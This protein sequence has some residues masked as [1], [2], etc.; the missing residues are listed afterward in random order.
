MNRRDEDDL[1]DEQGAD[2]YED[3]LEDESENELEDEAEFEETESETDD[4]EEE[5]IEDEEQQEEEAE[6]QREN[7]SRPKKRKEFALNGLEITRLLRVKKTQIEMLEDR[8]YI[9]PE[10]QLQFKTITFE[11]FNTRFKNEN[12]ENLFVNILSGEY[13]HSIDRS[14]LYVFYPIPTPKQLSS[15]NIQSVLNLITTR[16]DIRRIIIITIRKPSS[17]LKKQI[18]N[19]ESKRLHA[20]VKNSIR[21]QIFLQNE[22]IYNPSKHFLV[23]KHII[24]DEEE[25]NNLS[26]MINLHNLPLILSSDTQIK[27]L[28]GETG[29]VVK[30][31]RRDIN[32]Y[33]DNIIGISIVYRLVVDA[34]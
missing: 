10:N 1:S 30:V 15:S 8:G 24:L 32:P 22:L 33:S 28:G 23:P 6:V 11:E 3:E 7:I 5:G 31:I 20:N 14:K 16:N 29:Q 18:G 27:Y 2:V 9:I 4:Q 34:D 17:E 25:V 26:K 19:I 12:I 13:I 21:I